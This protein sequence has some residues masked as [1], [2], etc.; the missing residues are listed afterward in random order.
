MAI[1]WA[2]SII[3]LGILFFESGINLTVNEVFQLSLQLY[4]V[5]LGWTLI[6]AFYKISVNFRKSEIEKW[7]LEA[8][9]K[10]AQLIA[11]KSQINPHFIFNSLNNIR[12]LIIENPEKSRE[13]IT[14]LSGLLRYS[15]QFNNKEKVTVREE[16]SIVKNYLHLE[17]I[18]FEDRLKFR[19][20]L[21][22]R[23]SECKIPPMTIQVLVENAIKHGI[24][25]IPEGGEVIVR[26]SQTDGNMVMEVI[27]SGQLINGKESDSTGIGLKNANER[28]KY[29]F[30]EMASFTIEN[31]SQNQVEA[32]Y[33]LPIN[34][35]N[36]EVDS[37]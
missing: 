25:K 28:M 7:K 1:I 31:N 33:L 11:L 23:I 29:L 32:R 10:D 35:E 20:E 2:L 8:S 16:I 22:E 24:S 19:I 3:P 12:S 37:N 14:H 21:D 9:V 5:Y 4:L 17:S 15:I 30:G 34:S 27:N 26:V 36:Y 6:Y 18:Q 13:M